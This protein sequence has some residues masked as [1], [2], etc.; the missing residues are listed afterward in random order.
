MPTLQSM[1]NKRLSLSHLDSVIFQFILVKKHKVN[2]WKKF[3]IFEEIENIYHCLGP[4]AWG[5]LEAG[6][7]WL[8]AWGLA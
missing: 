4:G 5:A 1:Q 8:I 2:V 6:S 3:I 7:S